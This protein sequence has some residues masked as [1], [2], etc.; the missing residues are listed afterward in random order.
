MLPFKGVFYE[1]NALLT[2]QGTLPEGR[3]YPCSDMELNAGEC[4]E[5]Y[6]MVKG[7]ERCAKFVED[8]Y[9]CRFQWKSKMRYHIMR[10]ERCKKVAKGEI[11]ITDRWGQKYHYDSFVTGTFSP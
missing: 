4:L 5:A 3:R 1:L 6:G 2:S 11:P 8:L 10:M 7:Q 9:E